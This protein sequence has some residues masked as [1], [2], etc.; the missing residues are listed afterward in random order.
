MPDGAVQ[1][2]VVGVLNISL[3][4]SMQSIDPLDEIVL[5]VFAR[6]LCP[7]LLQVIRSTHG[8]K[9][10]VS[11]KNVVSHAVKLLLSPPADLSS[12]VALCSSYTK[13]MLNADKAT[14]LIVHEKANYLSTFASSVNA[15]ESSFDL[16]TADATSLKEVRK[17]LGGVMR[18]VLRFK[19]ILYCPDTRHDERFAKLMGPDEADVAWSVLLVPILSS[20][21]YVTSL[22]SSESEPSVAAIVEVMSRHTDVAVDSKAAEEGMFDIIDRETARHFGTVIQSAMMR[23]KRERQRTEIETI[24]PSL[25]AVWDKDEI[26][27]TTS[28]RLKSLLG[29]DSVA[30]FD[31]DRAGSFRFRLGQPPGDFGSQE[32][33]SPEAKPPR[34]LPPDERRPHSAPLHSSRT[35]R[36]LT[37]KQKRPIISIAA[38]TYP[39]A[40][41]VKSKQHML[42]RRAIGPL[43]HPLF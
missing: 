25:T 41:V 33:A 6:Q 28:S 5:T 42:I 18:D 1:R 34:P 3:P 32:E 4:L 21:V 43:F 12:L 36:T 15:V 11:M 17:S 29:V 24:M 10:S 30:V 35:H 40:D 39:I 7:V 13:K 2:S 23:L 8:S 31:I 16:R 37:S 26:F 20:D 19:K 14:L 22:T 27:E 38:N 9:W